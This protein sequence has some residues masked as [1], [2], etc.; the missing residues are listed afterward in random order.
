VH[1]RREDRREGVADIVLIAAAVGG[2]VFLVL[3]QSGRHDVG[4]DLS[5][6]VFATA[7]VA[8]VAWGAVSVWAPSR[9]HI[10]LLASWSALPAVTIGLLAA[11]VAVRIL[12]N[13]VRTTRATEQVARA[14]ADK[15]RTLRETD[16]TLKRLRDV[17]DSLASSEARLRLL[18]DVAVDGIVELDRDD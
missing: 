11:A 7:V 3:Q 13:Q 6:V 10:G 2:M 18:F 5:C 4:G 14:L 16:A 8:P 9:T 12:L 1:F 17:H 15:D